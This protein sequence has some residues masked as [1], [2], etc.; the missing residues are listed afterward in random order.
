[1]R[2]IL[3][4]L[5]A[6]CS[7]AAMAQ[8]RDYHPFC[9]EGK[10]WTMNRYHE[11]ELRSEHL[12]QMIGDT[13]IEGTVCKKLFYNGS[14]QGALFEIDKKVYY[15]S[16]GQLNSHLLYD[17]G[18]SVG[19]N[20]DTM[21]FGM[22]ES[23]NLWV[24]RVDTEEYNGYIYRHFKLETK[25]KSEKGI[26][27][28]D[29]D[30]YEGIGTLSGP[31]ISFRNNTVFEG[32]T[33]ENLRNCKMKGDVI[34]FD[35]TDISITRSRLEAEDDGVEYLQTSFCQ[36]GKKWLV[37]NSSLC[38]DIIYELNGDTIINNITAYKMYS[39]GVYKGA[40]FDDCYKTFYI[41][42]DE[43]KPNL[44]YNLSLY[45]GC[46]TRVTNG[47]TWVQLYSSFDNL[48]VFF[49]GHY[50]NDVNLK[51]LE[52]EASYINKH[53]EEESYN[54]INILHTQASQW[55]EGVGSLNG[56]M[57][58]FT[59][60][61]SPESFD[62]LLAC[63]TPNEIIYDPQ[64]LAAA[65]FATIPKTNSPIYDLSGRKMTAPSAHGIYMEGGK[66]VMR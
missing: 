53:N 25:E 7:V 12:Y 13:I 19:D 42:P 38:A 3:L 26:P 1:M 43:Q 66:K 6:L 30:W 32:L 57:T 35:E 2:N 58:N 49:N 37:H 41:A 64:G 20:I 4:V 22:S 28:M 39:E 60:P 27:D 56:P 52:I 62:E 50:L 40:F 17:F 34:F 10:E 36:D 44:F 55:I 21:D 24:T 23:R 18:L 9:E 48:P 31:I 45:Y 54:S 51:F 29:G 61:G 63:W 65:H 16:E 47:K 11:L 14:Y 8:D 15:I 33:H 5:Y 46:I 59:L